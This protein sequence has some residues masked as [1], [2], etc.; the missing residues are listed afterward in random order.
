MLRK[1][2]QVTGRSTWSHGCRSRKGLTRRGKA[3]FASGASVITPLYVLSRPKSCSEVIG[4]EYSTVN[5]SGSDSG[6]PDGNSTTRRRVFRGPPGATSASRD[7]LASWLNSATHGT[8]ASL[9][10]H[11]TP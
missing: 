11:I 7:S 6:V 10:I 5:V 4:T 2:R 1:Q 8:R 9:E 3:A